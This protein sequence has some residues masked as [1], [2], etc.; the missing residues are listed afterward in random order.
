V[1]RLERRRIAVRRRAERGVI[2][3]Y[4]LELSERRRPDASA[5]AGAAAA[6]APLDEAALLYLRPALV[7]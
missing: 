7:H 6:T 1:E 2:A 5:S 3:S 4:I